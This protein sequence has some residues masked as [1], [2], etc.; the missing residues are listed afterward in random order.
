[1][2]RTSDAAT[3]ALRAVIDDVRN[4]APHAEAIGLAY[5][6]ANVAAAALYVDLG[7]IPDRPNAGGEIVAWLA[8]HP[9]E[10]ARVSRGLPRS[11][12]SR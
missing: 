12:R 10:L 5:A 1:M 9:L 4:R 8:L 11:P 7:F 3:A 6:P 2:P